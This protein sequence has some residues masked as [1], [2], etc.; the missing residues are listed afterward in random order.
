MFEQSSTGLSSACLA[1]QIQA[2]QQLKLHSIARFVE[3]D[4]SRA[5]LL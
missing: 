4:V 2:Y 3:A 5:E 1:P